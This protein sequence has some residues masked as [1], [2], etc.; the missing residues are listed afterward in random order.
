MSRLHLLLEWPRVAC[1][2]KPK[3]GHRGHT[4]TLKDGEWIYYL[5]IM[6][7]FWLPNGIPFGIVHFTVLRP[8]SAPCL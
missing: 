8:M 5:L 7:K 2:Q 1:T 6:S 3:P 4:D